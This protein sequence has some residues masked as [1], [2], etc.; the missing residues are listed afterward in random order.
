MSVQADFYKL[1]KRKNSTKQPTGS[2][3]TYN[4]DLK[5]GTSYLS[6]ILLLSNSGK[7]DFNY[8]TFQGWFYFISDIVS[9]RNDL[10][11]I[12]GHVDVLATA[13]AAIL[14]TTAYVLYDSVSN[15]EIPDNRLPFKTSK[16]VMANSAACPFTVDSGCY[17]LSLTGNHN[18]TGVYKCSFGELAALIDDLSDIEDNLFTTQTPPDASQYSG[19]DGYIH[20]IG[21]TLVF[22]YNR[23]V[24]VLSQFFGSKD[25]PSNIR[26]C[27]FIPFDR[28]TTYGQTRVYL[29]TF[30][31]NVDL[32]KL[33]TDTVYDSVSVSIPWQASDYRRR[34]PYTE[35]YLYI[36]YVGM[37]KL[38][39][40]NLIGQSTITVAYALSMRDGSM[41]ITV[42]SGS[43][44]IGQYGG[45]VGVSVPIGI[46]SV[47]LPRAAGSIISGIGAA[48]SGNLGGIGMA[49]LSFG[50]S[51]TPNFSCIGGLDGQAATASN[52]NVICYSVFHD[53]AAAPNTALSEVGSPTMHP[54]SLSAL[55]GFC[56]CLGAHVEGDF[57]EPILDSVDAF[58]NSGFYIE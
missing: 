7:P 12:Y 11:E 53:T 50:E 57:P 26:Q 43:E 5:S 47:D 36:P 17:I 10:W 32:A 34:S 24:R 14:A 56:Q 51:V 18:S 21:D 19:I 25:I 38:S 39:S 9:V 22:T 28:G 23:F 48:A 3:T 20:Y 37:T 33:N 15:T 45:N 4:V 29:G 40:E 55:T 58:L 6:P 46:S 42:S 13:K 31:T 16:S 35:L 1:S 30:E 2:G 54:K 49:A 8:F 52:Q 44:I 27:I 41:S